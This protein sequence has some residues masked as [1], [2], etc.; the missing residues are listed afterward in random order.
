VAVFHTQVDGSSLE[1]AMQQIAKEYRVP[2][3][4]LNYASCLATR[5]DN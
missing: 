1:D 2:A 4:G 5:N 3:W